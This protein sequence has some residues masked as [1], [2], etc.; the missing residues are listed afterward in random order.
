LVPDPHLKALDLKPKFDVS[1]L[2]TLE[3]KP[4]QVSTSEMEEKIVHMPSIDFHQN[5]NRQDIHLMILAG[6]KVPTESKSLSV[7]KEKVR[8]AFEQ[9]QKEWTRQKLAYEDMEK[10]IGDY[11]DS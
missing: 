9:R 11:R 7:T 3:P 1:F 2:Q 10:Y 4:R 5:V 6:V 8:L